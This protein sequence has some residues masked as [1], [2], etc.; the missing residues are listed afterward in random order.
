[1]RNHSHCS[2]KKLMRDGGWAAP[3]PGKIPPGDKNSAINPASSSMPSDWYIEKT[4]VAV[5][6]DKKQTKQTKKLSRGHTLTSA[7]SEAI[8]PI[9]V[10][11]NS[12]EELCD[13]QK[14]V[15]AYQKCS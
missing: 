13:V 14:S 9:Q 4:S 2:R 10:T 6:N 8:S 15:G 12:I 11:A 3:H 1:M 7:T 5:T